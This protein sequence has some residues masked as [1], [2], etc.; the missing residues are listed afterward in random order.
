MNCESSVEYSQTPATRLGAS[1][2]LGWTNGVLIKSVDE[3]F[4]DTTCAAD[5]D[6]HGIAGERT[7]KSIIDFAAVEDIVAKGFELWC[8]E[9]VV[10]RAAAASQKLA[11]FTDKHSKLI[12]R[13]RLAGENWSA[14]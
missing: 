13:V 3:R 10:I 2:K 1:K 7:E 4:P 5:L 6:L 11:V 8:A 9:K 12:E 14:H